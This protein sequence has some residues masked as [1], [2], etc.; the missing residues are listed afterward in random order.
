MWW[1]WKVVNFGAIKNL[2]KIKMNNVITFIE[3]K[4]DNTKYCANVWVLYTSSTGRCYGKF[5]NEGDKKHNFLSVFEGPVMLAFGVRCGK[6]Y[7]LITLEV[8]K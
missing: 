7:S 2:G 4:P 1:L 3:N 5:K 6:D 8:K